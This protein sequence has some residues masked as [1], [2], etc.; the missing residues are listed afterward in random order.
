MVRASISKASG[1]VS[2]PSTILS[3]KRQRSDD[4]RKGVCTEDSILSTTLLDLNILDCPICFE[5]LKI[6]IFQCDNG[7]IA[8]SSCCPKLKNKCPSCALPV[9]HIRNRVM[10]TVLESIVVLC[11]NTIRGCNKKF[12]YGKESN[13]EKE[14]VFSSSCSC[15]VRDCNYTGWYRGIYYH[16]L[17]SHDH[18]KIDYGFSFTV[19]MNISDK[20]IIKREETETLLFVVQCFKEPNGVYVT[21]SC[22]APS[23]PEMAQFSYELSYTTADG[24]TLNFKSP[25]V[26]RV[27]KVSFET[28]QENFMLIPNTLLR[29]VNK[30]L[31]VSSQILKDKFMFVLHCLL[32]GKLLEMKIGIGLKVRSGS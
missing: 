8:C 14:C 9:G 18:T 28:P 32:R 21:V 2:G 15:P 12:S 27:L 17:F 19:Q 31:E 29:D 20:M 6:P 4:K 13:H 24:Y 26:K 3:Q 25:E 5:A 30:V 1:E 16:G 11:R 7:H 10:E 22:I 23:V